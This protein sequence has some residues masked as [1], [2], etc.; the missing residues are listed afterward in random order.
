MSSTYTEHTASGC[1]PGRAG[2]NGCGHPGS[3][4]AFAPI[5]SRLFE[6]LALVDS[7]NSISESLAAN[8]ARLQDHFME[9]LYQLLQQQRIDFSTKITLRLYESASLVALGEHPEKDRI[10]ACLGECP[11]LGLIFWEIASQS[12]ALQRLDSLYQLTSQALQGQGA[13]DAAKTYQVSLKG[14]MNHFYFPA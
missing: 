4:L 3:S 13:P 6:A 1:L 5:A 14:E 9:R 11:E 8:I 12:A 7:Q 10:N 2:Q